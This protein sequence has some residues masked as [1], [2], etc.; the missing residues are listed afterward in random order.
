MVA[1]AVRPDNNNDNDDDGDVDDDN[2]AIETCL[3][4]APIALAQVHRLIPDDDENDDEDG[5]GDD[6]ECC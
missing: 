6:D 5:N 4:K 1:C 3:Q 2:R